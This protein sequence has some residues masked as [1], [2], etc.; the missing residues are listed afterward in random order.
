MNRIPRIARAFE[1]T[2]EF[3]VPFDSNA[4]SSSYVNAVAA[5]HDGADLVLIMGPPGSGKSLLLRSVR[6]AVVRSGGMALC[7]TRP[8]GNLDETLEWLLGELRVVPGSTLRENRL[9]ALAAFLDRRAVPVVMLVDDADNSPDRTIVALAA[10]AIFRRDEGNKLQVVLASSAEID[11]RLQRPDLAW[12]ADHV[13][14]RI[15]LDPL[16]RK[17]VGPYIAHRIVATRRWLRGRAVD[18]LAPEVVDRVAL[19]SAGLPRLVNLIFRTAIRGSPTIIDAAQ[20]DRAARECGLAGPSWAS[21]DDLPVAATPTPAKPSAGSW[22]LMQLRERRAAALRASYAC[23]AALVLALGGVALYQARPDLASGASIVHGSVLDAVERLVSG[24]RAVPRRLEALAATVRQASRGRSEEPPVQVAMTV[25]R[26]GGSLVSQEGWLVSERLDAGVDP[27]PQRSQQSEPRTGSAGGVSLAL[28]AGPPTAAAES[29]IDGPAPRDGLIELNDLIADQA[30]ATEAAPEMPVG[31]PASAE[32]V[33]RTH[34]DMAPVF[35]IAEQETPV[36]DAP[37]VDP[38]S[39][40]GTSSALTAGESE[41]APG[42]INEPIDE[43]TDA[44]AVSDV[45]PQL[46]EPG[47]GTEVAPLPMTVTPPD[48]VTPRTTL[49]ASLEGIGGATQAALPSPHAEHV[50]A[51]ATKTIEPPLPSPDVSADDPPVRQTDPEPPDISQPAAEPAPSTTPGLAVELLMMRG[52]E[53]LRGGDPASARLFFERAAAQ[54]H[55][56]AMASVART[57][58]PIELRRLRL[59][60][61]NGHPEQAVEWYRRAIEAGDRTSVEQLAALE[62]WMSRRS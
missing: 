62:Q 56:R 41:P 40:E 6:D 5:I 61:F 43:I 50:S 10:L 58:D 1:D 20:I 52:D 33:D 49:V 19:Y 12:V 3:C 16:T 47:S 8:E 35:A 42:E 28:S 37:I 18:A 51:A 53:M 34:A 54:G 13:G 11:K 15:H 59:I 30:A 45:P 14:A 60:S 21:T 2:Q 24:A 32:P 27:G 23:A 7:R 36:M 22:I 31:S 9:Q 25:L 46:Q 48:D 39:D 26:P 17:E 38:V 57:Y 4:F 55:A 29:V 44:T